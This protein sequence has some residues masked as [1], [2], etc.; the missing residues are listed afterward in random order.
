MISKLMYKKHCCGDYNGVHYDN[1][2]LHF[3]DYDDDGKCIGVSIIKSS[4][5]VGEI[6]R[7]YKVGLDRFGSLSF[8]IDN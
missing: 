2:K 1:Y 8:L 5:D 6:G 3:V 7:E 4:K